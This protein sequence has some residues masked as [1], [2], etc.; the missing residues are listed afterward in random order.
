MFAGLERNQERA[1]RA[2]VGNA[3]PTCSRKPAQRRSTRRRSA[4]GPSPAFPAVTPPASEGQAARQPRSAKM[5]ETDA[6][7]GRGI[8]AQTRR[9]TPLAPPMAKRRA[10][11]PGDGVGDSG[12]R[13][14]TSQQELAP[15]QSRCGPCF[16]PTNGMALI[17]E[18]ANNGVNLTKPRQNGLEASQVTPVLA[19]QE[20]WE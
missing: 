7:R 1:S 18:P 15:V 16:V 14:H 9:V 2:S 19:R 12:L 10:T 3:F 5:R 6:A 11:P 17:N 8:L 20:R 4:H 13:C